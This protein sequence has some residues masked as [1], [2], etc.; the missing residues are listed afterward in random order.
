M[1]GPPSIPKWI[2]EDR[3]TGE[4]KR[5]RLE[6]HESGKK[7]QVEL[8]LVFARSARETGR[9]WGLKGRKKTRKFDSY[10]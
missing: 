9:N 5:H 6:E 1:E 2:R 4:S 7:S 3:E 10:L 8:L